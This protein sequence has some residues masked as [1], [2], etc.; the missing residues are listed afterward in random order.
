MKTFLKLKQT[1]SI[2]SL[3]L[4]ISVP[5]HAR[6]IVYGKAKETLSVSFG[7]ETLFRFPMEVKTITEAQR[8]EIRPANSEEPDYSVLAVKP[9]MM[10]GV[11]DIT[12]ILSDGSVIRTQL[13]ISNRSNVKKDSIYDF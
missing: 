12:F 2:L 8:F 10:E 4:L 11:A 13:V 1:L 5:V 9:R 7:V 3:S 6:E